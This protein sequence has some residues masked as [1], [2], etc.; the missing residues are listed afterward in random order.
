MIDYAF[1]GLAFILLLYLLVNTEG[2]PFMASHA[3]IQKLIN[4]MKRANSVVDRAAADDLK[5]QTIIDSFEQ[6]LNLNDENMN[7]IAEVEKVMA[8][9][10]SNGG[11]ALDPTATATPVSATRPSSVG[12][13]R[14]DQ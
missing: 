12:V 11:P 13:G 5:H 3:D 7:K 1:A 9:L 10:G 8:D 6:R 4:T 14:F 2:F